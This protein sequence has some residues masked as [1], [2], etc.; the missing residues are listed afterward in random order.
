[1][2][3]KIQQFARDSIK[4]G[5]NM[6]P[7]QNRIVFNRM[8]SP[9]DLYADINTVVDNMPSDRLDWA[10]QQVERTLGKL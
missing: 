10:M 1:M 8:Y 2:N 3:D 9:D 6:L 5:L 7:E 4:R